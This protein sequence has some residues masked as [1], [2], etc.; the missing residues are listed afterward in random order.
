MEEPPSLLTRCHEILAKE[1]VS[2]AEDIQ[3]ALHA[4]GV[5]FKYKCS[6]CGA[7]EDSGNKWPGSL[8]TAASKTGQLNR[9]VR[10][11]CSRRDKHWQQ[12]SARS[13]P[14]PSASLHTSPPACTVPDAA[15]GAAGKRPMAYDDKGRGVRA[16]LDDTDPESTRAG[17]STSAL[18]TDAHA[19]A[20]AVAARQ[21]AFERLKQFIERPGVLDRLKQ[22]TGGDP[23]EFAREFI[24]R[25]A[26]AQL[27]DMQIT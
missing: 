14:A 2:L 9:Q 21:L 8:E 15:Q 12:C 25:R 1:N 13:Q 16:R 24:M 19:A 23:V 7:A 20:G 3:L 5:V 10:A 17:P 27:G 18:T 26:A 22:A 4:D 6:S 11:A